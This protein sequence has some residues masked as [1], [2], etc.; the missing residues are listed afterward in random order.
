MTDALHAPA[1]TGPVE[2]RATDEISLR[3]L[4]AADA[5]ELFRVVE[6][7]RNSLLEAGVL[8]RNQWMRH[9]ELAEHLARPGALHFGIQSSKGLL[10]EIGLR[11]ILS[12]SEIIFWV[13]AGNR[14]RG[15]ATNAVRAITNYA[16]EEQDAPA[17]KA[18]VKPNNEASAGVL[19]KNGFKKLPGEYLGWNHF[20]L[21]NPNNS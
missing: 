3:Q 17:I 19:L 7:N 20:S 16:F 1:T 4:S 10:G 5:P 13:D 6:A 9:E 14:R 12:G 18:S 2:L 15:I 11:R 8:Q 21:R